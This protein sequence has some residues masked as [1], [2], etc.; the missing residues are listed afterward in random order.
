MK[1]KRQYENSLPFS[2]LWNLE[3][4]YKTMVGSA[5]SVVCTILFA[6][7]NGYLGIRL[8]SL[9]HFSAFVFYLFLIIIRSDILWTEKQ[10]QKRSETERQACRRKTFFR[11]AVL[12]LFLNLA[13]I[14]PISLMVVLQRPV[15]LKQIPAIAMA[16]YTTYKITVA[17]VHIRKRRQSGNILVA[18]LRTVNFIDALVSV[19]LLQNTLIM[20]NQPAENASNMLVLTAVSSA[21]IYM[22]IVIVSVHMLIKGMRQK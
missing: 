7:Y 22:I 5:F 19:L 12:L 18:E 2:K 4:V 21:V 8:F 11:T 10:N 9:W 6:L 17:S 15:H 13:L 1:N 16:A 3:Y 20:V 14:L